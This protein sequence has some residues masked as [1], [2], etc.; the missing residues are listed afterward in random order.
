[1]EDLRS[2]IPGLIDS[3]QK[4]NPFKI[5]LFGSL[6]AGVQ[7][8]DSDIDLV[9]ILN[10][11]ALPRTA[12]ERL[13][14]KVKVRDAIREIS[15]EIPIDLIVYTKA[16]LSKLE[17]LQSPFFIEITNKGEILYEKAG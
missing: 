7:N 11:D 17:S 1:M 10:T 4:V 13:Q 12:D 14:Y 3:L 2:Y 9:V 6:A 16:E 5:I 8:E 15:F